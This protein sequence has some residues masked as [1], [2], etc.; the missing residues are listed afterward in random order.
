MAAAACAHAGAHDTGA[1][2]HAGTSEAPLPAPA[3][4]ARNG[5]R[6]TL[7]R[8]ARPGSSRLYRQAA[9]LVGG[10]QGRAAVRRAGHGQDHL[11]HRAGRNL[12]GAPGRNLVCRMAAQQGRPFGRRP[13]G[14]GKRLQARQEA[15]SLHS[16]HR[17]DRGRQLACRRWQQS[18]LVHRHHH[19]A[20]RAA[21][22]H[23]RARGRGGGR[24]HQLSRPHR[25]GTA[26][27]RPARHPH[28]HPHA[29]RGGSARHRQVP[30]A[31]GPARCRSGWACRGAGRLDR[32][33]RGADRAHSAAQGAQAAARSAAGGPVRGAGREADRH[34][35]RV[36]RAHCASTR[37]GT[38]WRLCCWRSHAPSAS[39][40]STWPRGVRP[41][42]STRRSRP[43]RARWWSGGS[44]SPWRGVQPSRSCWA[45]SRPEPA[46]PRA[47]TWPW[48]TRWRSRPSHAGG[49]RTWTS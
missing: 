44:P 11:R 47:P 32:R 28:R 20:Q 35:A 31:R 39:P 49:L 5:G 41:R 26:A 17:R 27:A 42:S 46:A 6:E 48:P 18:S 36:P 22:R 30:P 13:Q 38:R 14:D 34:P 23:P 37:P 8:G 40:C 10:R 33:P 9:A 1:A 15:F 24:R 16:V 4:A 21:G 29:E 25:S 2:R 7:G 19:R 12:Q 45:T 3:G 43:S